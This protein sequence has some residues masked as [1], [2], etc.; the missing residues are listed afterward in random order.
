MIGSI[1]NTD[2]SKHFA[3]LGK[4]KARLQSPEF[5]PAGPDKDLI[6]HEAFHLADISNASKPFEIYLN[7][8]ELLFKEFFI[9]GDLERNKG[10]PISYLM[11]RCTVNIAKS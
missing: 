8:T 5:E 1:L 3:E 2:M 7:W 9:Q 10:I 6:L 11:D 4:L